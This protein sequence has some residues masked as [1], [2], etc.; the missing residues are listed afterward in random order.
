MVGTSIKT[1]CCHGNRQRTKH[2]EGRIHDTLGFHKHLP[3]FAHT[4]NL[5]ATHTMDFY[6][7]TVLVTKI[8]TIVT[9]FKQSSIAAIE[10][11]K[12]SALKLIQCIDTRWNSILYVRTLHSVGGY[13]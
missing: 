7:A 8:K 2:C 10:L 3:C 6:D 1:S 5:V 4:L 12:V 9:F 11:R 13:R